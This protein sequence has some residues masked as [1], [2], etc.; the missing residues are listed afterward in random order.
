MKENKE[1]V[2]DFNQFFEV[3]KNNVKTSLG[4]LVCF[5]ILGIAYSYTLKNEYISEGKLLPEISGNSFGSLSGIANLIGVN[6]LDFNNENTVDLIRPDL[7]PEI[8][9]SNDF[10]LNLFEKKIFDKGNKL[11]KFEDYYFKEI[12]NGESVSDEKKVKYPVVPKG[13]LV[14]DEITEERIKELKERITAKYD[15]KNGL[16]LVSVK[17]PDPVIAAQLSNYSIE[18]IKAYVIEYRTKK[19]KRDL[20]FLKTKLDE[21][22]GKHFFYQ[23]KKALYS[24]QFQE[25]NIRFKSQ[26]VQRERIETQYKISGGMFTELQ[27]KYEETKIRLNESTPVFTILNSPTAPVKKS[28]PKRALIVFLFFIF[29]VVFLFIFLLIKD[30]NYKNIIYSQS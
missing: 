11:V 22:K 10:F 29:G 6:N 30:K 8:I 24:D 28:E 5:V 3:V 25:A 13:F 4:I 17:M 16:I 23:E 15:N 19:I 7:F 20:D 27:K 18:Y 14:I 1:N 9:N 26:D 21:S 2:L 12:E